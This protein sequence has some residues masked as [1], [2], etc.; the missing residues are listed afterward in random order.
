MSEG[1]AEGLSNVLEA[2][3]GIRIIKSSSPASGATEL[4]E[5][6]APSPT[7]LIMD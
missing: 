3:P 4:I 1:E 2:S 7:R 5:V 6:T